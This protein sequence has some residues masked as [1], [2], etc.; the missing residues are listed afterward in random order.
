MKTRHEAAKLPFVLFV[1][2]MLSVHIEMAEAT[3][4]VGPSVSRCRRSPVGVGLAGQRLGRS[5]TRIAVQAQAT[6]QPH[7]HSQLQQQE[8]VLLRRDDLQSQESVLRVPAQR[9][10]V[11]PQTT[12]YGTTT[13][14]TQHARLRTH[15]RISL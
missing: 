13:Y 7:Q 15:I 8:G 12:T 9:R 6:R 5:M 11:M 2:A 1:A 10:Q 3:S 4:L 14:G